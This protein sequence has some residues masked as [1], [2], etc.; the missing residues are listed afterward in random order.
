MDRLAGFKAAMVAVDAQ[1]SAT[2]GAIAVAA[3]SR[4]TLEVKDLVVGAPSG[5]A[6]AR[7][8]DMTLE[9]RDRIVIGGPSGSG[10]SSLFRA[11]AGLWPIGQGRVEL[12]A[13]GDVL[14]MPQKPYFPLG[15]LRP[16]PSSTGR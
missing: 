16:A 15:T 3:G 5:A 8:D 14:V 6:M 9:P 12:P 4:P 2:D 11:L 1:H 13:E 7:I 10:K